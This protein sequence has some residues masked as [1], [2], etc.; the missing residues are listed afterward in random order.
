MSQAQILSRSVAVD[1]DGSHYCRWCSTSGFD[2]EQSV[3]AHLKGCDVYQNFGEQVDTPSEIPQSARGTL[4]ADQARHDPP[5]TGG[6]PAEE[7]SDGQT[8][9]ASTPRPAGG[10]AQTLERCQEQV[11]YWRNR[12]EYWKREYRNVVN[13]AAH[14][15]LDRAMAQGTQRAQNGGG[16]LSNLTAEDLLLAT[17]FLGGTLLLAWI[18]GDPREPVGATA[19]KGG[20][21]LMQRLR[22]N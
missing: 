21:A 10:D 5:R 14:G 2:G 1:A 19:S 11:S 22:D 7:T 15:Q 3:R 8:G 13:H 17:A 6:G 12:A 20:E 4:G 18:G 16:F 9:V